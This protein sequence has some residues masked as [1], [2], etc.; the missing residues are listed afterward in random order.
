MSRNRR[1]KPKKVLLPEPTQEQIDAGHRL[2]GVVMLVLI[3]SILLITLIGVA[4]G[5]Q[6]SLAILLAAVVGG[7]LTWNLKRFLEQRYRE[8]YPEF[9]RPQ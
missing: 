6:A 7:A 3:F 2:Y 5:L 4:A 1:E 8:K 9:R